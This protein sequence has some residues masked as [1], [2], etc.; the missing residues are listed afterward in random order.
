M[1]EK[2]Y[3]LQMQAREMR[4]TRIAS[5]VVIGVF[6]LVP[7]GCALA[8]IAFAVAGVGDRSAANA[9]GA[10]RTCAAGPPGAAPCRLLL[11]AMVESVR[12]NRPGKSVTTSVSLLVAGSRAERTTLSGDQ[13]DGLSAGAPVTVTLWETSIAQIADSTR[14]WASMDGPVYHARNDVA[15]VIATLAASLVGTRILGWAALGR[16]TLSR[17]FLLADIVLLSAVVTV[18]ILAAAHQALAAA[19]LTPVVVVLL[20]ASV[21]VWPRLTWVRRP[22]A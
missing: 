15:G 5:W 11:P 10:A 21:T 16:R 6:A 2:A 13:S 3:R 17:R 4:R 14:T 19:C 22:S 12:V 7:V 8:A 20:A 18:A 9:Y 1:A